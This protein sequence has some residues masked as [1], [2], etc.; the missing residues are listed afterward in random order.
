MPR[1]NVVLS[2]TVFRRDKST[3]SA[4][5]FDCLIQKVVA[6]LQRFLC[7]GWKQKRG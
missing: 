4:L 3:V 1:A 6:M 7:C 5:L 2:I